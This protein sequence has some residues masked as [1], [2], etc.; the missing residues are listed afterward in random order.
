MRTWDQEIDL[1]KKNQL[2]RSLRTLE[3]AQ[4]PRAIVDGKEVIMLASNNYLGLTTKAEIIQETNKVLQRYGSGSGGSRLTTGNYDLHENLEAEISRFKETEAAVV[5]NTGYMAN[6]G[7]LTTVV[8]KGD[9]IICDKLNHASIIDACRLS[10]A[11]FRVYQHND[12][13]KLERI[14]QSSSKYQKRLIVTD[15]VFSMD[16]D[17]APLAD[18][19][20]LAKKYDALTMI[21]DAHGTGVLGAGGKGTVNHFDLADR[22]DIQLGTLS[23]ALGAEG[24]FVAGTKSLIDLLKN[25]ARPFIYSTALSPVTIEAA[26]AAL[27]YL[28][29]NPQIVKNLWDNINFLKEGLKDLG[30]SLLPSQSAI[31]PIVIGDKMRA[32]AI[33]DELFE[34]GVLAPA[35]R[36]PTVPE[37]SSRIRV[38]V[39]A[40]H[41]REDLK[42]AL[43]AFAKVANKF[44]LRRSR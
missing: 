4:S 5:F 26:L 9:L 2:Y 28:Q 38:T 30:Y 15:G 31:V 42:E 19:V 44:N 39:M 18:I 7:V 21:D 3:S 16:G 23:K 8:G 11:K 29:D 17:L 35:I 12:L 32:M 20:R 13:D 33:S 27:R 37:G 41:S 14:L 36:P 25:K 24:G 22:I 1:L 10:K 6:I 43:S 34:Q 40:N